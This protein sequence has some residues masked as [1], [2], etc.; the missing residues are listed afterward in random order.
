ME[1]EAD[2]PI[3]AIGASAGGLEALERLFDALS[4]DTGAAFVV[5]LHSDPGSRSALVNDLRGHTGMPVSPVGDHE[6]LQ[7]NRVY[8]LSPDRR[9]QIAGQTL[10][11]LPFDAS[12]DQ[13]AAIP[14]FF[15]S[16]TEHHGDTLAVL[17]SGADGATGVK[18]I[19]EAGGIVLVQ[20]PAEAADPSMPHSAIAT[21]VADFVLP[22]AQLADRLI[23]LLRN[24]ERARRPRNGG[25]NVTD[26]KLKLETLSRAHIDLQNFMTATDIAALL[27]DTS[28]RIRRFTPRIM[29]IFD[30]TETD[31]GRLITGFTHQLEYDDLAK[32]A[33]QVIRDLTPVEHEVKSRDGGWYLVR[34]RP[35][36]TI[37]DKIDGVV[38]TFVGITERRR[39]EE[40]LRESEE[41]LRQEVRVVEISRTPIFAWDFD[42]GI[43]QWNRGSEELYGYLRNEAV[44]Q[45]KE[46]LLHTVVPGSSFETLQQE[47]L[48]KGTWSGELIHRTKD[49]RLLTVESQ[50]EL[51]TGQG[52]RVVLE[53]TRDITDRRRWEKRQQLL[54]SELTHRV[55]NALTVVQSL[56]R[57]TLRTTDTRE[58]FVARFEGRLAAL[59]GAYK[60][61]VET[62][63]QGAE[64]GG[65]AQSQ[66][67][68]YAGRHGNRLQ[69]SGDPVLLPSDFATPFGL[70]L[71]EL[72]TNAAKYGAF[73]TGDGRVTLS[74]RLDESNGHRALK[75]VWQE[76]GGPTIAAPQRR[77]FGAVLIEKALPGSKVDHA[78][79][80][81]GVVCT[82]EVDLPEPE[83]SDG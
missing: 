21:G 54:L 75:V 4:D 31:R 80:P 52:R 73:S 49:G 19:K 10:S 3:V 9:L 17:L 12:H 64:L 57:Q 56:A 41:R 59:A 50:I 40:A 11:S 1:H 6:R 7:G 24:R 48:Q 28:L 62:E 61:L 82:I 51:F 77:G 69:I 26:L 63:W 78:F 30:I 32:H 71:H 65:L 42:G 23:E 25:E 74:W 76:Q 44:G 18:A 39:A 2:P 37:D 83:A 55:K 81:G 66:L 60:L 15:C 79:L 67:N 38:A 47:L 53:S 58:E 43:L 72:A 22:I 8:I 16:L 68:A 13:N 33:A 14:L 34:I 5:L 20:D 35:C 27:L 29:D 46:A 36:R 45:K 70:I